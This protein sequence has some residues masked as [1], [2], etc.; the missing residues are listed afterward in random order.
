MFCQNDIPKIYSEIA[1]VTSPT[2]QTGNFLIKVSDHII[3]L[4]KGIKQYQGTAQKFDIIS[5]GS[6]YNNLF[7]HV[8]SKFAATDVPEDCFRISA[9]ARP[10][11]TIAYK[12]LAKN[13]MILRNL[14]LH[15]EMAHDKFSTK[16][17]KEAQ[18]LIKIFITP[19]E[20]QLENVHDCI[21]R[22]RNIALPRFI[23]LFLKRAITSAPIIPSRI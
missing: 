21:R 20:A 19:I 4:L 7:S 6:D 3:C 5:R 23:P 10:G 2:S 12:A 8:N 13:H 9:S 22:I 15:A 1:K 18:E 14:I 16:D 11:L 17:N